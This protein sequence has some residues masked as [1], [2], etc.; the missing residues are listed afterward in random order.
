M[1]SKKKKKQA[2]LNG[3]Q[4][5]FL[6]GLGHHLDPIVYVG[7]E[8]ITENLEQSLLDALKSRELIKVKLG[9]NCE[10]P[11]KEAAE[12]LAEITGAALVQLIGKTV[13]L[14]QINRDIKSDKR[15]SLPK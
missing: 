1:T 9:Q 15:I 14:Y 6:R 8:G 13:L 12:Q 4:K 3:K 2:N 7:K 10:V 5:K 11:K